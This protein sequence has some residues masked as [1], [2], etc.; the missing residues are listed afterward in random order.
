MSAYRMCYGNSDTPK[1]CRCENCDLSLFDIT[2]VGDAEAT[3]MVD[4]G[5][6]TGKCKRDANGM[7]EETR[8]INNII[9][10]AEKDGADAGGSYGSNKQGLIESMIDYLMYKGT[11]NEYD[12]KPVNVDGW[13]VL[14]F[15]YREN[16]T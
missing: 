3:Y 16:N 8:L 6:D 9:L 7:D 13:E 14:Q 15:V 1:E 4:L 11:V 2:Q 10:N 5:H 12:I